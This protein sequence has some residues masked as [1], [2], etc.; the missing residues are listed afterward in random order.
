MTERQ[1]IDLIFV[2]G[3]AIAKGQGI[4]GNRQIEEF[5]DTY[6]AGAAT[7]D[8]VRGLIEAGMTDSE[9]AEI[10]ADRVRSALAGEVPGG[11]AGN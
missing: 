1:R 5:I 9:I 2:I 6:M 4:T 8:N 11:F 3:M 7:A 10:A